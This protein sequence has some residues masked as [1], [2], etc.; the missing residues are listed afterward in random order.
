MVAVGG[1]VNWNA[2]T[3]PGLQLDAG[4]RGERRPSPQLLAGETRRPGRAAPSTICVS[5]KSATGLRVR[6]AGTATG[7]NRRSGLSTSVAPLM[8]GLATRPLGATR[9]GERRRWRTP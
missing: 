5:G 4:G 7:V 3:E 2:L 6:A 9:S 1:S 8:I